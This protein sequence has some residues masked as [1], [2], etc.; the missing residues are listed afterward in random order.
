MVGMVLHKFKPHAARDCYDNMLQM[1]VGRIVLAGSAPLFAPASGRPCVFFRIEIEEEVSVREYDDETNT[2]SHRTEWN[3]VVK[4]EISR[5]FYIQDGIVKV[6]VNAADRDRC[7][8][9]AEK[10][11]DEGSSWSSFR[12]PPPGIRALVGEMNSGYDWVQITDED[13]DGDL[14]VRMRTGNLRYIERSF[15]INELVAVLGVAVPVTDPYTGNPTKCM[16]PFDDNSLTEDWMEGQGWEK[17]DVASWH[18][19]LEEPHVLISDNTEF[20]SVV[21]VAPAQDLPVFMVQTLEPGMVVPGMYTPPA[22]VVLPVIAVENPVMPAD[23]T[24]VAPV[25]QEVVRGEE[26]EIELRSDTDTDITDVKDVEVE[27]AGVQDY[28]EGL[29]PGDIPGEG[30]ISGEKIGADAAPAALVESEGDDTAPAR[31]KTH[32]ADA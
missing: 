16:Q 28:V 32:T 14:E 22:L 5:D 31:Q 9:Q 10:N 26:L 17:D 15:D 25:S 13:R 20:T 30:S 4:Q 8:I 23:E 12:E 11:E 2:T 18:K 29:A 21:D 1:L 24:P 6:F 3:M 27:P 19:L 7:K